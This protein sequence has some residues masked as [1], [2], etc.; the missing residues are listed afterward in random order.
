MEKLCVI[1]GAG[2]VFEPRRVFGK[3]DLIVA[4]DGGYYKAREA[5]LDVNV[6]VGDFD[7]GSMP[8]TEAHVV[9]L[10]CDKNDTDMLAAVK[11]GL[12]RG[13][14]HFVIYGGVGGRDDH[15]FANISLLQYLNNFGAHGF[16]IFKDSVATIITEEKFTLPKKSHGSV[17]VFA[18]GG[19]TSG[20]DYENLTYILRNAELTPDF[21]LGVSNATAPIGTPTVSV[22]H[23]SLLIFFPR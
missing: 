15:T 2:E 14:R 19:P 1:F 10:N 18:Y 20:V 3:N 5:G 7:S 9:K 12:R 8:E 4:A 23:G 22:K 16:L 6:V 21:P 13:Y 11:L 17:S